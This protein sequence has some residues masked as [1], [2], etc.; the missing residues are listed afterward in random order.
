MSI[1]RMD[2]VVL[3]WLILEMTH[4]PFLVGL[5]LAVRR[6]GAILGPWAGVVADR[7]DRRHLGMTAIAV[8]GLSALILTLLVVLRRLEVWHLFV[9][10]TLTGLVWAFM[11]P[12]QQSLQ[13]DVLKPEELTN[14]VALGNM[15]MNLTTIAAPAF[16]GLLLACCRPTRRVFDWTDYDMVLSLNW[17]S[18]QAQR[19]YTTTSEGRVLVSSDAGSSWQLTP[20]KLPGPMASSLALEGAATGLQWAYVVMVALF[21]IQ[22]M[23][24]VMLRPPSSKQRRAATSIWR[25]LREG[26]R[27]SAGEPGLWTPLA[28]AALVNFATFP[29]TS[30]LL[31]VF[32]RDVFSVGATGLGWLGASTG[33]GALLGSFFLIKFGSRYPP[34]LM[35]VLGTFFWSAFQL[36]LALTPH[37]EMALVVLMCA[38]MAQAV[39]L[40]SMTLMLLSTSSSEMRGRVM[41][42][43]SMAV[44]PLFLGSLIS[45]A[46]AQQMGAPVATL[47]FSAFSVGVTLCVMPWVPKR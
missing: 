12:T 11:Q 34:G 14:G 2:N 21:V 6:F 32:A 5:I 38:G 41:G 27:Y 28:L 35:M 16:A 18:F 43:R 10:S 26:L 46:L 40:T 4:S 1:Q 7:V 22:L 13:A 39:S 45:G 42:L 33:V 44:A 15:A 36:L 31:P 47:V 24:Y 8:M 20:F 23:C 29:L 9:S 25:N 37:C 3:G 17:L 19:L 30:N